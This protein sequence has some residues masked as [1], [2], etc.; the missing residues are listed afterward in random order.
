MSPSL[1]QVY[2]AP[3]A[4][5]IPHPFTGEPAR[6][7]S[8]RQTVRSAARLLRALVDDGAT[9]VVVIESGAA[10]LAEVCNM[11]AERSKLSL[12]WR[13][14]KVSRLDERAYWID[15]PAPLSVRPAILD[16]YIDSGATLRKALARLSELGVRGVPAVYCYAWLNADARLRARDVFTLTPAPEPGYWRECG[17]YPFENR[18]DLIGHFFDEENPSRGPWTV[19]E[20]LDEVCTDQP[21]E[22]QRFLISA[23]AT[24]DATQVLSDMRAAAAWREVA[25]MFNEDHALRLVLSE[26]E[27][28]AE[29]ECRGEVFLT[30]LEDMYG[31]MWSPYPDSL[32]L[33]FTAARNAAAERF[34]SSGAC[35]DLLVAYRPVRSALLRRAAELCEQRR[36]AWRAQILNHIEEEVWTTSTSPWI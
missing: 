27:R 13:R 22:L 6:L 26:L 10:P 19:G 5:R 25:G 3:R 12:R 2:G 29:I 33:D 24:C 21:G 36:T 30:Q 17:A 20:F 32:H 4:T 1:D 11:L 16:E 34:V 31:P 35:V 14:M 8:A 28:A 23:A 9:E 15:S 7:M 18:L